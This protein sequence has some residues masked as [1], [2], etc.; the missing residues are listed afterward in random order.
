M[1]G[2]A[3]I[4]HFDL[5][6]S[7]DSSVLKKMG[8][9]LE[10]RGPDGDGLLA[11]K[12]VGLAHRRL[13]IIDLSDLA[14]QPF[15]ASDGRYT[16]VFNGEI[17]NFLELK[18]ELENKGVNF[19]S[20]SDTE[21]LLYLYR[22]YGESMLEKLNGM[23][24][25]TIYD[26]EQNE[27]FIARD[28]IGIKP[29][30][31]QIVN[32]SFY[33]ASEPKAFFAIG[34]D[35]EI[36]N[37]VLDELLLFRYVAGENT[38]FK[39]IKRLLPGYC[40]KVKLNGDFKVRR[41]WNLAEKIIANREN[42]PSN[43]YQWFEDTFHSS[44]SYRSISDV[45]VGVMLSG[46]LDSGSVA[47]ALNHNNQKNLAAF[48]VAFEQKDYNEGHLAR[49]VAGKFGLN[50][51]EIVL[52]GPELLKCLD[53]ASWYHDEPLVHQ[54]DAQMLAL[55]SYAKK[56]VT[57]LLS[58]E[59]GDEF[60][61]GYVRYKPLNHHKILGFVGGASGFLGHV[62]KG[63]I[64]NRF[65]KLSRYTRGNDLRS[66][67]HLNPS[68]IYPRDFK[69]LGKEI[70]LENFDYR[71]RVYTEAISL[72]PKEP[73][74][75]A[76]YMDLFIH[77]AS[78]LDRND[79]MTMGAGIECRVPFMDYRL[80]EMIPA[81]DS[82]H[83]LKG[84]KGKFLL[85]NSVAQ[86]LPNDVLNFKKLGFSVPWESYF[87]TDERFNDFTSRLSKSETWELFEGIDIKAISKGYQDN[88]YI[89]NSLVRQVYMVDLWRK[90]YNL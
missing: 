70:T 63:S 60:M 29:F 69:M 77:M 26:K 34:I 12:N 50:Y 38:C 89:A 83:L 58:G 74:R 17:F 57:V 9:S 54:N 76:M 1:C 73:A 10:H 72:Y 46:G 87:R 85:S 11:H 81:L 68:D 35:A 61:G 40:G 39:N 20:K 59:G 32:N 33:F 31:Y 84:K 5:E 25:F 44:I 45:P 14:A 15:T 4:F 21:V 65:E 6:R 86:K 30:Y 28:R 56:H 48:T 19:R 66:L 75:Q 53:Q 51:H 47:V 82:V 90:A 16:I 43:P 88:D 79:R 23:F 49:K 3:G 18:K 8:D 27:L 37:E 24:A 36:N 2:I 52:K 22:L 13:A 41:W 78:V 42:V 71:N 55:S 7:V 80:M 67:V 64:V 62:Y